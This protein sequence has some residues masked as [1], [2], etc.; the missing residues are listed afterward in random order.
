M[1]EQTQCIN[2]EEEQKQKIIDDNYQSVYYNLLPDESQ[3]ISC[4]PAINIGERD[5]YVLSDIE[6]QNLTF[7][8]ML[9]DLKLVTIYYDGDENIPQE[10]ET[11]TTKDDCGYREIKYN[12]NEEA[13]KT[14]KDVIV[15]CGDYI[16]HTDYDND[17]KCAKDTV[18]ILKK[19]NDL[20][21]GNKQVEDKNKRLF[22]IAGNH[23]INSQYGGEDNNG[24]RNHKNEVLQLGL[25][26]Q[27]LL[28]N[29]DGKKL[30]FQHTNFPYREKNN[31]IVNKK[32]DPDKAKEMLNDIN[33]VYELPIFGDNGFF[34]LRY[35]A[36]Q[37]DLTPNYCG[38]KDTS[39]TDPLPR[40]LYSD[41]GM[42]YDAKFI[43]HDSTFN[44]S[45]KR[46][47]GGSVYNVHACNHN[48]Q[49]YFK[50]FCAKKYFGFFREAFMS[51][52][53]KLKLKNIKNQD[54]LCN[55]AIEG[56]CKALHDHLLNK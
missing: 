55:L 44:G 1:Q 54:K 10:Y 14:F 35:I 13:C 18:E 37:G 22:L 26:P 52:L 47:K 6:G 23:D 4:K 12:F 29:A 2:K 43:G 49:H 30:L 8:K 41:L 40:E 19:L 53:D 7:L 24:V 5:V 38:I 32:I 45:V 48:K 50:F 15:L 39:Y 16:A 34:H 31:Y 25:Y 9:E 21:N 3:K 20:L 51:C 56:A 36:K 42:G 46:K 33:L 17:I 11:C 27:L 28:Q